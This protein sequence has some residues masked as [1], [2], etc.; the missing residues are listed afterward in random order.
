MAQKSIIELLNHIGWYNDD[1]Q[2][3]L[4][5]KSFDFKSCNLLSNFLFELLKIDH[6]VDD[7]TVEAIENFRKLSVGVSIDIGMHSKKSILDL[8]NKVEK[9][10]SNLE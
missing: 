4:V 8:A 5:T 7:P 10:Y 3:Q 9:I 2:Y 6:D 1:Q